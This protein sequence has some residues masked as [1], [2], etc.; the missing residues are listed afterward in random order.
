MV[1]KT[2]I[3]IYTKDAKGGI[4][5]F[6]KNLYFILEKNNYDILVV[7][8][9]EFN[10]DCL[11]KQKTIGYYMSK[12]NTF[13]I[14]NLFSSVINMALLLKEIYNFKPKYIFS[15]DLYANITSIL[16]KSIFLLET[17]LI[18]ST[19]VNLQKH[20]VSGRSRLF[21]FFLLLMIKWLYPKGDLHI[22]PSLEL[23]QS[24][25]Q[26]LKNNYLP[27]ITIPYPVNRREIIRLSKQRRI[28]DKYTL[29]TFSRLD[30]QKN[31]E[32]LIESIIFLNNKSKKM[33]S[34]RILGDGELEKKLKFKFK[35]YKFIT[36]SGWK[37]IL[38][39]I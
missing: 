8:H 33:I 9:S 6:I 4:G 25:K 17:V 7:K 32:L 21:S 19:H 18:N 35:K 38:F 36:F 13:S 15:L 23:S 11:I 2:K 14:K 12:Q 5:T 10:L 3:L 30:F 16:L 22:T 20:I 31:V 29:T 1:K 26:I 24:I 39:L 27:I 28:K 34:L 37:K